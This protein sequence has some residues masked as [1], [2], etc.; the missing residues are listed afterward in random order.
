MQDTTKSDLKEKGWQS[1]EWTHLAQNRDQ[2]LDLLNVILKLGVPKDA[3][4]AF[5][6]RAK[7][8]LFKP[9]SAPWSQPVSQLGR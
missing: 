8:D 5:P 3:G 6:S 2:R 9:D 7:N 4:V 1:M